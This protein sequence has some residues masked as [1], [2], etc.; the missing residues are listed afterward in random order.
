MPVDGYAFIRQLRS[1]DGLERILAVNLGS[2]RI[3]DTQVNQRC[4]SYF[5][6]FLLP[7]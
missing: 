3:G 7:T 4:A 1:I 6:S 5:C 2:D